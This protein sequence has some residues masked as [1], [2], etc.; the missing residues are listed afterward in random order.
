MT[1][2]SQAWENNRVQSCPNAPSLS[3]LLIPDF[4]LCTS[5]RRSKRTVVSNLNLKCIFM[6]NSKLRI[7]S[8]LGS[9]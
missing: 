2:V 8:W 1:T 6:E 3:K 5:P 7:S 9:V 4:D